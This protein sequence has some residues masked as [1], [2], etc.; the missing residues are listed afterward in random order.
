MVGLDDLRG[1]FQ[2]MISKAGSSVGR[3]Q[4]SPA[5]QGQLLDSGEDSVWL[6]KVAL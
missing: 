2:P 5:T 6:L 4:G 1:L 3:T